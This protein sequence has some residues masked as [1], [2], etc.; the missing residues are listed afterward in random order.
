[1]RRIRTIAAALLSASLLILG[2]AHAPVVLASCGGPVGA[3]PP[4]VHG[5]APLAGRL[6]G[7]TNV[8]ISGCQF[9]GTT[10]VHFGATAAASFTF[11][12]SFEVDA[13]SPAHAAGT[14]DVT[15]TTPV[16]TSAISAADHFTFSPPGPCTAVTGFSDPPPPP[17]IGTTYRI[18]G[19]ASPCPDPLYEF[20]VLLPGSG[21]WQLAQAY[22]SSTS[23]QMS[24]AGQPSGAYSFMVWA[25]DASSPGTT[26]VTLGRW[27]AYAVVPYRLDPDPCR[28]DTATAAPQNSAAVGT[29]V[30]I[31]GVAPISS[32]PPEAPDNCVGPL[33][34][35]WMLAPGAGTWVPVQDYSFVATF[36]WNTAGWA[37]GVYG[38]S[39]WARDGGSAGRYSSTYGR[40]DALAAFQ[41]TLTTSPCSLVTAGATPG[42]PSPTSAV[43]TI[44]GTAS[45]CPKPLY[46]F[47]MLQP[48]SST[49][50]LAQAYSTNASFTWDNGAPPGTYQFQVW[51]RDA[52]SPGTV[53]VMLGQW[54]TYASLQYTL[55][56]IAFAQCTGTAVA[57]SPPGGSAPSGTT[58]GMSFSAN[59]CT[60]PRYKLWMQ[61]PGS[62]TWQLLTS[63][64]SNATVNWATSGLAAGTYLF[65]LFVHDAS[66]PG[67]HVDPVLGRYDAY[68]NFQYTLT[69][70]ACITLSASTSPS[71]PVFFD[72]R[73][74]ITGIATGCPNPQYEF[75]VLPPGSGTWLLLQAYTSSASATWNI[76]IQTPGTYQVQVWV[77]D[78]SSIGTTATPLGGWDKYTV[79]TFTA[80]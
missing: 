16:T 28:S 49:W 23:L 14:V 12:S 52:S 74:T 5:I 78:A 34:K 69:S 41:Y 64:H 15:V 51:A 17:F 8:V 61:A 45:G 63:Y 36:T 39:V 25:R 80:I 56:P 57:L 44:T 62:S 72:S 4:E 30:T 58:V 75:W 11:V 18:L 27:D 47:W 59:G 42:S 9:D 71:G 50:Q 7:G 24:T 70:Q 37:P 38:F 73:V 79:V 13:V 54:D 35:F 67:A 46:E 26:S 65:R 66:G 6:A 21:T 22:S 3:S 31:T 48:G 32:I 76:P 40:Y 55:Q 77:R 1:M 68:G 29:V 60:N 2:P 53:A 43:I 10:A 33:F 19:S 20:W